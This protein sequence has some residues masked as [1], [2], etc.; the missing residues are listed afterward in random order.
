MLCSFC[1]VNAKKLESNQAAKI[2][3]LAALNVANMDGAQLRMFAM[4]LACQLHGFHGAVKTV[5]AV[6]NAAKI[7]S[8]WILRIAPNSHLHGLSGYSA[9]LVV[10]L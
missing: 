9:S 4:E 8:V 7:T 2:Q 5:I 3:M 6:K 1:L 10:S